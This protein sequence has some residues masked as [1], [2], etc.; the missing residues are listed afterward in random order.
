MNFKKGMQR[1]VTPD[2]W[3][4]R[5]GEAKLGNAIPKGLPKISKGGKQPVGP[6]RFDQLT[7]EE[8][9]TASPDY[10]IQYSIPVQPGKTGLRPSGETPSLTAGPGLLN[11]EDRVPGKFDYDAIPNLHVRPLKEDMGERS[12]TSLNRMGKT[13]VPAHPETGYP[14]MPPL[15]PG[16]YSLW[17]EKP[18]VRTVSD[19]DRPV[20]KPPV[21]PYATP[22]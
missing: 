7:E 13:G 8:K 4:Y 12:P 22:D 5:L 15:Q 6:N 17:E 19:L 20:R 2:Y 14:I 16:Q 3:R 10:P 9:K 18:P 21:D 1:A 11:A